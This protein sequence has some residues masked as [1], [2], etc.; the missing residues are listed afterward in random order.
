VDLTAEEAVVAGRDWAPDLV[1]A[2]WVDFVGPLVAA[3]LDVPWAA[4]AIG[5]PLPDP[6]LQAMAEVAAVRYADR[7]LTPTSRVAL[8][9]PVPDAFHADGWIAPRDRIAV[10]SAPHTHTSPTRQAAA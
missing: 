1:V 2:E 4:V 5:L 9:D 7:G 3:M 10:R 6:M 8:V